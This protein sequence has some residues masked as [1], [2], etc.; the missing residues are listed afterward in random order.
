MKLSAKEKRLRY[1]GPVRA[2]RALH[3]LD[4]LAARKTGILNFLRGA[5][6]PMSRVRRAAILRPDKA[7]R[8]PRC[9]WAGAVMVAGP[10]GTGDG[11]LRR[12]PAELSFEGQVGLGGA[13]GEEPQ[14]VGG[15]DG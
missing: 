5:A 15:R 13:F 9:N 7:G 1:N 8:A 2:C 12:F 10:A 4:E 6:V 3:L 11:D 14:G